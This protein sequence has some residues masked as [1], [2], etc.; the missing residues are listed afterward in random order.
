MFRVPQVVCYETPIPKVIAFLKKHFIKV[1]YISLVNLI[2]DREVV[3][4][5]VAD[6]FSVENIRQHLERILPGGEARQR[7]LDGYEEVHRRLGDSHAPDV[8][9][10]LICE[11]LNHN[12][13]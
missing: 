13:Y 5:L 9:A 12:K 6:T 4:E 11:L 2:V 3:P 10:R 7:M 8:A 1:K